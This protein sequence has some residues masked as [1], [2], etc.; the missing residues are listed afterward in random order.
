[1][2]RLRKSLLSKLSTGI[3]LMAIPIF[4][5]SLGA[6]FLQSRYFIRQEASDHARSLLDATMHRIKKYM[7]ATEMATNANTWF[8]EHNFQ[9]DS[10]LALSRRIV[11][12]NGN[13]NSCTI[14]AAPDIFPQCGRYFSVYSVRRGDTIAS[15]REQNYEYFDRQWYKAPIA[16]GES[17]WVEP[18]VDHT[19]GPVRLDEAVLTYSRPLY[20]KDRKQVVGVVCADLSFK[21]LKEAVHSTKHD[22]ADSYIIML[23]GKGQYFIHPDSTRLL[24]KSIFSDVDASKQSDIIAIGHEMID[25]K[26][27]H[28]HAQINGRR[29]YVTYRPIPS[30]QWSIA[31]VCPDSE[32]LKSYN[33]L[34]NIIIALILRFVLP[35]IITLTAVVTFATI[36]ARFVF[37][38][39]S[40]FI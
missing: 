12:L 34:L 14:S 13:T 4:V 1:M 30:S 8:I 15:I 27:G 38:F 40:I 17:C 28:M 20:D 11:M 31:L 36:L 26:T 6:L 3:T 10:L 39:S 24:R 2:Y 29:C 7:L 33:Q 23:G 35:I 32:I 25:G 19:E 37:V 18:V 5:L 16:R 22:Y 21:F 9:P